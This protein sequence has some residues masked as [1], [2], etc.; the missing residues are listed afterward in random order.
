MV[1]NDLIQR[2]AKQNP[3]LGNVECRRLIDAFFNAMIEQL[4]QGGA[5]QLRGF[6]SF[7]VKRYDG[8]P[9]YIPRT[10]GMTSKHEIVGIRFRTGRSLLESLNT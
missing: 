8:R 1:K 9:V 3:K 6:G 4:S 10:G 5:I 7:A 2:I